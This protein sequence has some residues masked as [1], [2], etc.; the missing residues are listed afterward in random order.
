MTETEERRPEELGFKPGSGFEMAGGPTLFEEFCHFC[1]YFLL[2]SSPLAYS[3]ATRLPAFNVCCLYLSIAEERV[4]PRPV[5]Y[6]H[7]L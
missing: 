5:F 3:P 4:V 1:Y 7:D 2:L 6:A